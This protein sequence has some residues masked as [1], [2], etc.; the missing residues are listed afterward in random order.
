MDLSSLPTDDNLDD[1]KRAAV[2]LSLQEIVQKQKENV[3]VMDICFNKCVSKIGPKLSSSEQKCIWDCANSYFYTNVF[4]NQR[5]EQ[6]T[7]ILKS[8]SD[9]TNL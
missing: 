3:K 7:K 8:N 2:L 4:L 6:M 9:Y 1:K 5:L